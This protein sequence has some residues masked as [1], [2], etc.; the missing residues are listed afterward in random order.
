MKMIR[1]VIAFCLLTP[2]FQP[3]PNDKLAHQ[4]AQNRHH[5]N[6]PILALPN[7]VTDSQ[8]LSQ[9]P[10]NKIRR[11][12]GRLQMLCY[13]ARL[14]LTLTGRPPSIKPACKQSHLDQPERLATLMIAACLAYIWMVYLGAYARHTGWDKIIHR[15]DRCDLSLFQLGLSLLEHFLNEGIPIPVAFQMF[16][17]IE[18]VPQPL[19]DDF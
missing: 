1:F 11:L 14:T 18:G 12:G 10:L 2:A 7:R 3:P 4:P 19:P 16:A 9:H 6:S 17:Q 13:V 15:T 5:L 8:R